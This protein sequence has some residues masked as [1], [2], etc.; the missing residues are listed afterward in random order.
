LQVR[1]NDWTLV[2]SSNRIGHATLR[3]IVAT[4][5]TAD[6]EVQILVVR[7]GYP[8]GI[9]VCKPFVSNS[10]FDFVSLNSSKQKGYG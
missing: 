2:S 4:V 6:W 5:S 3:L 1:A 8:L 7:S 9:S 10:L